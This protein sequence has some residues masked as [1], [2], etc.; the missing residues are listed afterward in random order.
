MKQ[1]LRRAGMALL[2]AL[3]L[4]LQ[5]ALLS[6][7]VSAEMD[8]S[9]SDVTA[10]PGQTAD[11]R[12]MSELFF[13]SDGSTHRVTDGSVV[14]PL[15]E[16][17]RSISYSTVTVPKVYDTPNNAVRFVIANYSAA[18]YFQI[19]YTYV[20]ELGPRTE[21]QRVE[22]GAYYGRSTYLAR[23]PQADSLVNMTLILP[24]ATGNSLKLFG[25]ETVRVWTNEMEYTENGTIQSCIYRADAKTVTVKGAP[26]TR[27]CV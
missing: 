10:A 3:T 22:I 14:L 2:L 11:D 20:T 18:T 15:G 26:L 9:E 6:I 1:N 8:D 24:E 12:F 7:P 16:G 23:I 27:F 17:G 5:P 13:G 25:M 4:F 19:R 21:T